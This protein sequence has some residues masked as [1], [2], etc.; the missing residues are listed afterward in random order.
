MAATAINEGGQIMLVVV[1]VH[2]KVEISEVPVKA[3]S[4][5][6]SCEKSAEVA[7]VGAVDSAE[8]SCYN[9]WI[10]RHKKNTGFFLSDVGPR[11]V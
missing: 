10:S 3:L 11:L 9:G 5:I 2:R 8:I 1:V 7:S 4:V 6:V